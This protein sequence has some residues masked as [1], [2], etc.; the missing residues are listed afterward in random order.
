MCRKNFTLILS[1]SAQILVAIFAV[2]HAQPEEA[3]KV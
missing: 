3:K 1:D 2:L